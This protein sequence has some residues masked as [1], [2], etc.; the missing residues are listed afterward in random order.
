MIIGADLDHVAIAA[1]SRAALE[2]RYVDE[3]GGRRGAGGRSP[4]FVWTQ[5]E[6]AN[7]MLLEMLEPHRVEENDFL[8][9]FLD[10]QGPGPH[11]LT[12]KVPH[13]EPALA[14]ARSA[15]YE[16][17]AVNDADPS[18]KE[19][20]LHPKQAPGIVVQLAESHEP[21]AMLAPPARAAAE[22]VHVGHALPDLDD[23]LRLFEGLL[24][25]RTIGRGTGPGYRW[26]ELGWVGPG[27]LRLVAPDGRHG[28][29][30][31][32]LGDRPGRLHHLAFAG[33]EPEGVTSAVAG[34]G[35]WRVEPKDNYGIRLLLF[36]DSGLASSPVG[37]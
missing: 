32:W 12:F 24:G 13:F 5:L 14:A 30:A 4:G 10:R 31:E 35:H 23:G 16:P 17:V 3:L 2:A 25:G 7:G 29:L 9:R 21:P 20:F 34:D 1:E 36:D 26:V 18:W 11:H 15:G 6:Y 19:A 8:R 28:S 33:V 27:R 22:L 37:L